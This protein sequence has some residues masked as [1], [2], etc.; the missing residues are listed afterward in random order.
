MRGQLRP[1]ISHEEE[2]CQTEIFNEAQR[3][4]LFDTR[5]KEPYRALWTLFLQLRHLD[6]SSGSPTETLLRLLIPD[7]LHKA[8]SCFLK[9]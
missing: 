4:L 7:H 6:P 8:T 9:V 2:V 3:T 1:I 5:L